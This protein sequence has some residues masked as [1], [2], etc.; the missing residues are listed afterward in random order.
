MLELR[1]DNVFAFVGVCF[2]NAFDGEIIGF[3]AAGREHDFVRGCVDEL[4]DLMARFF[5]RLFR[6]LAP[7]MRAGRVA[8]QFGEVRQ[9]RLHDFG[10]NACRG[11]V[12]EINF[13]GLCLHR[14]YRKF[15]CQQVSFVPGKG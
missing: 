13:S 15:S 8:K 12:V 1:R 3:R 7:L 10:V 2:G 14:F 9:H 4:G 11:A 5:H 6:A